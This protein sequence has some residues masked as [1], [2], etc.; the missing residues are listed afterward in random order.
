MKNKKIKPTRCR[1]N[2]LRQICNLIGGLSG[3]QRQRRALAGVDGAVDLCAA[4]LLPPL[5]NNLP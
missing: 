3:T 5:D 2:I 4:A 1:F